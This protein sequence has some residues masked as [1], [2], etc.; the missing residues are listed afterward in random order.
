MMKLISNAAFLTVADKFRFFQPFGPAIWRWTDISFVKQQFEG[1]NKRDQI[2][3]GFGT[4]RKKQMDCR[5][6]GVYADG[7]CPGWFPL[8]TAG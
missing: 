8:G 6:A 3:T 1:L 2:F 5:F 7:R 4:S